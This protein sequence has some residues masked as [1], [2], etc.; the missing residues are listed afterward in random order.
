[1]VFMI[2]GILIFIAVPSF[3][4]ARQTAQD[5]A[6]QADLRTALETANAVYA[7]DIPDLTYIKA[8]TLAAAE[9]SLK[10]VAGSVSVPG[11]V[12]VLSGRLVDGTPFLSLA[13]NAGDGICWYAFETDTAPPTYGV[14]A[15]GAGGGCDASQGVGVTNPSFP[16]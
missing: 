3:L 15:P 1:M 16:A 4:T 12:S 9:P 2:I 7:D 6:A 14:G 13:Q 10:F 11:S 5:H 8:D